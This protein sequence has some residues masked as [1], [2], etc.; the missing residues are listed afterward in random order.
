MIRTLSA[1][2]TF[3]QKYVFLILWFRIGGGIN[4]AVFAAP[5]ARRLAV[6]SPAVMMR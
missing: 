1:P 6:R 2:G 5:S 3:V 4:V